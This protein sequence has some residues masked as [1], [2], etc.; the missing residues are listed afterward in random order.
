[1]GQCKQMPESSERSR[2]IGKPQKPRKKEQ[3]QKLIND[4]KKAMQEAKKFW[5]QFCTTV[6]EFASLKEQTHF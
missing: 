4:K 2:K 6:S 1:M 3:K 5:K